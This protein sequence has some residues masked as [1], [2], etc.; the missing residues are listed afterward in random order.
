MDPVTG[1]VF[2]E[3]GG[4]CNFCEKRG[5]AN[6]SIKTPLGVRVKL[7]DFFLEFVVSVL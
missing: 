6:V 2:V 3:N 5:R 4:P 7:Y 1:K